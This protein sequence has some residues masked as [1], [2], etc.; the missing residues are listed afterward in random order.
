MKR[1]SFIVKAPS[2]YSSLSLENGT[3]VNMNNIPHTTQQIV[4]N[5]LVVIIIAALLFIFGARFIAWITGLLV[6]RAYGRKLHKKDLEKRRNTLKG[7]FANIW[8]VLVVLVATITLALQF[9]TMDQ[10][11]PIFASAGII[12]V[13]VGFGAQSLVRDFL[14]GLFIISENQYRVG[15]V[16]EI[17][18]FGG[19][20]ERIGSRSTVLRDVEGNV[21]YFPNGMIQHVINKTMDYSVARVKLAVVPE[22]NIDKAARIIDKIGEEMSNES[23]WEPKIIEAPHYVMLG[24]INAASIELIVSGKVQPSD[25][26]SVSAELRRRIL[27]AFEHH[28]IELGLT[29]TMPVGTPRHPTKH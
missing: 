28:H 20:V 12:G 26:W 8:R 21:H 3:L 5:S 6:M 22:T 25:Q 17:D 27:E 23:E 29:P 15:D 11:A 10:L 7:L 9:L 1:S 16:I 24:D 13:A 19:T 4:T 18:G 2:I 14:S